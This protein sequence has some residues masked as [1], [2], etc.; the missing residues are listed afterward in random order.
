M[1]GSDVAVIGGGAI[2]VCCAL[3]LARAGAS[4]T[5]LEV[6]DEVGAGC[7]AGSAGLICPSH[8]APL[9]TRTGLLLGLRSSLSRD[10]PF[11]LQLRPS[12]L[13]WIARFAAACT[14]ARERHATAVLRSLSLASLALHEQLG[15]ELGTG[16][17]RL[18]TFNVYETEHGFDVGR[19]EAAEHADA[20]LRPQ[21]LSGREAAELEPA[22]LGPVAGAVYY[23]DE[24]SGDPLEFV[25]VVG[26]A[27]R[28]AGADVRTRTEVRA[29]RS[30]GSRVALETADGP[31]T[32]GAVVLAAGAWSPR[33]ASNLR[34]A[35][36]VQGGKGYH[37]EYE[38]SD[39]DPRVPI[40]LQ[41]ARVIATPLARSLRLAGTL[42]LTGLD[43][44]INERRIDAIERAGMRRVRAL[45]G[46][47]RLRVWRGLRP[48]SPDGLPIVGRPSAYENLVLATGHAAL[49]F[50][51]APLTGRLVAQVIANEPTDHDLGPLH[52][53]RFSRARASRRA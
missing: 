6:G 17:R 13:P 23:A 27:A 53:D 12:L 18:G 48:V 11:A 51:L 14:P 34:L 26:D 20:G 21:V 41:E 10:G 4:V 22:L 15:A 37:V 52:P 44:S 33:L 9:A 30:R 7:S 28:Y 39:Q 42:E 35:L 29:L 1:N 38:P 43:L 5:L 32:A 8:A 46:R 47:P 16:V 31:L 25:R 24:L 19:R 2:G 36:P 3:E 40:F 49:G 50:T 45:A